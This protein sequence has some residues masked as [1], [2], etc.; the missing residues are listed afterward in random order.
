MKTFIKV[1]ALSTLFTVAGVQAQDYCQGACQ[2][3]TTNLSS[4]IQTN[5][6]QAIAKYNSS[7]CSSAAQC[8]ELTSRG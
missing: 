4:Q 6:E 1:I 8:E 3:L 7:Y 2:C 5:S